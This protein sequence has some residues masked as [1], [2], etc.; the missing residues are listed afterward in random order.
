[1]DFQT[2]DYQR[3]GKKEDAKYRKTNKNSTDACKLGSNKSY[4]P[5]V[6]VC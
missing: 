1:M 6:R 3:N 4:S 5:G 2:L